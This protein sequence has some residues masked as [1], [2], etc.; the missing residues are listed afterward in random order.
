MKTVEVFGTG[1]RKCVSVEEAIRD[2]AHKVGVA[3][4]LQH[5]HDP[6]EIAARGIIATPAVMVDGRL[7]HKGGV[8]E[9]AEIV[10]WLNEG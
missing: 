4:N 2:T 5:I 9:E 7:V 1:C 10:S 3:I 6:V 8:P